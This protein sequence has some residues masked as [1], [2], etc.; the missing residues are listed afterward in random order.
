M[1]A[2]SMRGEAPQS[3]QYI[4]LEGEAKKREKNYDVRKETENVCLHKTVAVV[5]KY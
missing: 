2:R 5:L 3:D 4:Q 1:P